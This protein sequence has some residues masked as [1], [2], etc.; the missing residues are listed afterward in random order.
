MEFPRCELHNCNVVDWLPDACPFAAKNPLDP[1]FRLKDKAM[2]A[3]CSETDAAT[4]AMA[5]YDICNRCIDKNIT[6]PVIQRLRAKWR[7]E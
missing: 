6:N 1:L 5:R 3:M 4:I 2:R 7:N